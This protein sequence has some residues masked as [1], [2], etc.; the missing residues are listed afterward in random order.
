MLHDCDRQRHHDS[1]RI[2]SW[3]LV[4]ATMHTK[5]L[6]VAAHNHGEDNPRASTVS[7]PT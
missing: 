2:M 1:V 7:T 4:V 3:T 6:L 5:P